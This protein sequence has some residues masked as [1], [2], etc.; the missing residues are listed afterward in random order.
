M[1]QWVNKQDRKSL[2]VDEQGVTTVGMALSLLITL[3]LVFS[4]MQTYRIESAAAEV[5]DVADAAALSAENRIGEF[6][7]VA[8]FCDAIVLS[9]TLTGLAST[10]LGVVAACVPPAASLS[11]GLIEAGSKMLDARDGF[12]SRAASVLNK[13]QRALPYIAAA[14][15]ANVAAANDDES[16]GSRYLGVALL[17]KTEGEPIEIGSSEAERDWANKVGQD[18]ERIR[19]KA[20]EAEEKA[21]EANESKQRA[22]QHDCGNAP[23]YCMY[24]RAE[25]LSG[26]SGEQNPYFSSIDTWSF[27]NALERARAYYQRRWQSEEPV[28]SDVEE[29]ARSALRKLFYGYAVKQM[30]SA[31]V[32]EDAEGFDAY[33]PHLP[34]NTA[35]MRKTTLYTSNAFPITA[36]GDSAR[37]MHACETCPRAVGIVGWGSLALMESEGMDVCPDCSF[38]A[39]SMG[40]VASASTSIANGFEYHYEVVA[41]EA[42]RYRKALEE[43]D[44]PRSEVKEEAGGL[45]DGFAELLGSAFDKRIAPQPP[46]R[47]GAIALVANV[48]TA[49]SATLGSPF[50]AAV[51]ELGTRVAVSAAT[52]LSEESDEGRDAINSLLDGFQRDGGGAMG[53]AGVLLD[54]WSHLLRAY[55]S[56]Q[57]AL[58]GGLQSALESIPLVGASGLGKWAADK[59]TSL[60]EGLGL[61]PADLRA[62]KAVLVNSAYVAEQGDDSASQGY[63]AMK[64]RVVAAASGATDLFSMVLNDAQIQAI[65]QIESFGDSIEIASVELLGPGG[66]SFTVSLPVPHA[67][68]E[69]G[70]GAIKGFFERIR[71]L[72][73]ELVGEAVWR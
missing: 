68:R 34:K 33:F 49:P 46:G 42:E 16:L 28:S 36:G 5:Q 11:K 12:A 48:G 54:A 10:G 6:M 58:S 39:A 32:H 72:H 44:G 8:Q 64:Q 3:A 4:G 30:E 31:Y 20:A 38:T 24:E 60:V 1:A 67:A 18:A 59:L 40:K 7:V 13:L 52:L 69:F 70:I 2:L 25:H 51:G 71:S 63:L 65:G 45:L 73:A 23:D 17:V 22:Y 62:R 66:P 47:F 53:A 41:S 14:S 50:V 37:M 56:G 26:M 15:A 29:Q 61:Q 57:Q 55:T 19:Q 43:L 21:K 27:S 35:E 9:L